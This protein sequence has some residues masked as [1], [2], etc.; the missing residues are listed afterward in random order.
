MLITTTLGS[1]IAYYAAG[2]RSVKKSKKGFLLYLATFKKILLKKTTSSTN[3]QKF[4]NIFINFF[5]NNLLVFFNKFGFIFD[6]GNKIFFNLNLN[7]SLK[8]F[9]KNKCIK[10]RVLKRK[11]L[12]ARR[13]WTK[14][15]TK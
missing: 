5:D 12:L 3:Q 14:F 8:S 15:S 10:R 11:L 6:G 2:K 7:N 9:K 13:D 4:K 1:I